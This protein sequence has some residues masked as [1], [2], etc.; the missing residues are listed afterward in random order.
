[1]SGRPL[2]KKRRNWILLLLAALI[3]GVSGLAISAVLLLPQENFASRIDFS[4]LPNNDYPVGSV[5]GWTV[6]PG[7]VSG[8]K[9]VIQDIHYIG[10][11]INENGQGHSNMLS[12]KGIVDVIY[13]FNTPGEIVN[14][15]AVH[16]RCWLSNS[17]GKTSISLKN[18]HQ[19]N[20]I[21]VNIDSDSKKMYA[22]NNTSTFF[23]K[24]VNLNE[25][26]DFTV[27]FVNESNYMIKYNDPITLTDKTT[28]TA[29][30]YP[31][32]NNEFSIRYFS[33]N[34]FSTK[35]ETVSY[36]EYFETTWR[37]T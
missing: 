3:L 13:R 28:A 1:M 31:T 27:Y 2:I 22:S 17:A 30:V 21:Q 7:A 10:N 11:M 5:Q 20:I 15:T 24:D 35:P 9:A 33:M 18:M 29:H 8:S 19:S 37:S 25:V 12:F 26:I 6:V 4:T 36:L 34:S 32:I 14:N 16:I 23:M